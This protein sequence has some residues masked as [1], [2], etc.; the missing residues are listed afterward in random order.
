MEILVQI[1]W[2]AEGEIIPKLVVAGKDEATAN[3]ASVHATVV[4]T[5]LPAAPFW[6]N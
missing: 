1:T 2:L 3:I 4:P 5:T 6:H